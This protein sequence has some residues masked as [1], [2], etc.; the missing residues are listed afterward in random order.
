[1]NTILAVVVGVVGGFIAGLG[2]PGGLP[3]IALFYAHTALST[4]ELAGT[5]STIFVF[6]TI[7]ASAMYHYSGDMDWRIILPL[8]PTTLLGTAVGTR[9]NPYIPRDIFG[10]LV[11]ILIVII[12]LNVVYREFHELE[13]LIPV[14]VETW[15]GVS[16]IATI[17]LIVGIIGGMFG[18]GGP[19]LSIP[20]LIFLG[21]PALNAIG[22]GLVQGIFV[23]ASTSL[24]YASQGAVSVSLVVL[25]GAPYVLSQI[26]GWYVAQRIDTRRL[27]IALGGMLALLGPYLLTSL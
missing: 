26:G 4:A 5:T 27:K 8:L 3:V 9:I 25:V 1:M 22:A 11:A 6:A 7:F 10:V 23:T 17:G 21:V 19:A 12:G 16:M 2:G 24:N 20:A 14:Q 15:R 18:I 13:P